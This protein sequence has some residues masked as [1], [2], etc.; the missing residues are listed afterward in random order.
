[1]AEISDS[2]PA[3]P[4]PQGS[5]FRHRLFAIIWTGAFLSNVGN[6][7]ENSAQNWA[8]AAAKYPHPG[9]SAFMSEVLNFADFAPALFRVL[10]AGVIT[11]HVNQ[12]KYLLWLQAIA[13]V[14]GAGLAVAAYVG[15]ASPWVV[16]AFTFAEGIV[17]ALNGPPWQ[18]VV[19]H[20][21]PRAELPRAIAANSAQFNLARLL[22]PFLA[23]LVILHVG[24]SAAFF[25]NA[26]SFV[27]VI[28]AL[29]RLPSQEKRKAPLALGSLFKDVGSGIK[30]V[31]AHKGLRQLSIMLVVFMFLSAPMQGLLA[32]FVQQVMHG[33]SRTYGVML[34]GIGAGALLG[35]LVIG[36][37]PSYYPRHHLIPLSMCFACAFMLAF[38]MATAV[39]MGL[40]IIVCVGFFWMLALNSANAAIQ[41]L[42]TDE[43]RGRVISVMLLCNQGFMPLGHLFAA[44]LT[45]WLSPQWI[46]R[47][48][49][50]TLLLVTLVFLMKREPAID[51]M[52]RRSREEGSLW[53]NIWEAIT[54]Q[55]HRSIPEAMR[56]DLASEKSPDE[57][58]MG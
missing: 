36:K 57:S 1:M 4:A 39:W 38:S 50:G 51:A 45:K 40:P 27:P 42:A 22:G 32:V 6:W 55:S 10:V 15:W 49:V 8:V 48:M 20:L 19:P 2:L 46:L 56:E 35:A 23:G 37:V 13:C 18:T 9:D 47:S 30:I 24:L 52:V 25:I 33:D 17:W 34:G 54:A 53:Q 12:K 5:I 26:A 29:T 11:D 21:V 44:F 58:R 41:L 3:D 16:I 28:I 43:N 7:M 31:A 14:L